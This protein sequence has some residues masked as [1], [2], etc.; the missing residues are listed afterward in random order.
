MRY[1]ARSQI[2]NVD[3]VLNDTQT[4]RHGPGVLGLYPI[5]FPV[6]YP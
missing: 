4:V 1:F 3:V 6:R 5:A 2:C